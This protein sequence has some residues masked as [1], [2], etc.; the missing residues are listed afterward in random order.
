[1][2]K[3]DHRSKKIINLTDKNRVLNLLILNF[4]TAKLFSS[5]RRNASDRF[6]LKNTYILKNDHSI[7][8]KFNYVDDRDSDV[9][10][11]NLNVSH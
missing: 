2:M 4:G 1:M 7:K 6:N 10:D 11:K 9:D 3:Y 8:M 5:Q